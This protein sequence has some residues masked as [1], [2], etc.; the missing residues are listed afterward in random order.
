MGLGRGMHSAAMLL[1]GWESEGVAHA[2]GGGGGKW[3]LEL[4]PCGLVMLLWTGGC[5]AAGL[6]WWMNIEGMD[7]G[8]FGGLGVDCE[9]KPLP[10]LR[11]AS[12]RRKASSR[13]G[14]GACFHP[15]KERKKHKCTRDREKKG[16]STADHLGH[17]ITHWHVDPPQGPD[18]HLL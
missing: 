2:Q 16:Q 5:P 11:E 8:R 18:E 13:W 15:W 1:Q 3:L 12:S 14:Q 17:C 10:G 4:R 6:E 9:G 7:S